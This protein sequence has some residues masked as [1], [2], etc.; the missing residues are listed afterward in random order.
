[1]TAP[2][3]EVTRLGVCIGAR[4]LVSDVSFSLVP[5]GTVALVGRS[6]SG[7]SLTAAALIG[8]LPQAARMTGSV[9]LAGRELTGLTDEELCRV[10]GRRISMVFQD[11]SA[12]LTPVHTVGRQVAEALTIHQRLP[13]QQAWRQAV[14]LLDQ[15]GIASAAERAHE[16]PHRFSGGM[17][18]RVCIA[19]ALA[20]RPAVIIADEPTS[21]LDR[22]IVDDV[23]QLL[24]TAQQQHQTSLLL[25]THDR[26]LARRHAEQVLTMSEGRL[27]PTTDP[28]SAASVRSRARD[29]R[30]VSAEPALRISG[31]SRSYRVAR[32]RPW[33]S[34]STVTAL[35]H[36]SLTVAANESVAI[37]GESGSGKS[38]LLREVLGLRPPTSGRIEVLGHDL[39]TVAKA[40]RA[41]LQR[42]IQ[43]VAQDPYDSLDPAHRVE[44]IIEEPLRIQ[45]LDRQQRERR[46]AEVLELVELPLDHCSRRPGQLS[47]GQRQRVA[48]ARA[49]AP[50]PRLLL[51][52]EPVS[53]L[54]FDLRLE[55]MQLLAQLQEQTDL[56]HLLVTHDPTTIGGLVDRIAVMR[57]G[58]IVECGPLA[59]VLHHPEDPYTRKLLRA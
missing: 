4:E 40:D 51:L 3:L 16:H 20:N 55:V 14:E 48:I 23:M 8:L 25:I 43:F 33:R 29:V 13:P 52:D 44:H 31:L 59:Q 17:R 49:I 32:T 9:R 34:A 12:S 56:A 19:M 47:G 53:S 50:S 15:V 42:Q 28:P 7:K 27:V 30:P 26:G 37:V 46:V 41:Q 18:Q 2:V 36:V 21:A 45:G 39:A 11:P 6:G 22:I 24:A 38:T 5:G 54:D 10:R 58:R 57:A 1:M 35:D